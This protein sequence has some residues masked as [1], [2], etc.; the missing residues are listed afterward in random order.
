[1]DETI[2]TIW[3]RINFDQFEKPLPNE[4]ELVPLQKANPVRFEKK[5]HNGL[6]FELEFI[7][8]TALIEA[9]NSK[10]KDWSLKKSKYLKSILKELRNF[11]NELDKNSK[12]DNV[13]YAFNRIAHHQF[14]WQEKINFYSLFRYYFL[15]NNP[16]ME[17][18]IKEKIGLTPFEIFIIGMIL[19]F[20]FRDRFKLLCPI[21]SHIP[22]IS[23]DNIKKFIDTFSI[24]L[25]ELQEEIKKNFDSSEK[26][27]FSF[28]PLIAK[29][30]IKY[31][32]SIIAPLPSFIYWQITKGLYYSVVDCVGFDNAFG[33]SFEDFTG[34]LMK[35]SINKK[36]FKIIPEH[37][38]KSGKDRKDSVDWLLKDDSGLIFIECKTKR[39]TMH[40]KFSYELNDM[41]TD[42]NKMVS[43]ISQAY[44][45]YV[46]YKS[47]LYETIKYDSKI[48]HKII[49]LTL[50]E[51][52]FGIN[53]L[54]TE[55][56]KESV[57]VKLENQ[58]IDISLLEE[59]PY[60]IMSA[61][62]YEIEIQ[63]INNLGIEKYFE[64]FDSNKIQDSKDKMEF[65]NVFAEDFDREFFSKLKR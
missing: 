47:N 5:M 63:A 17:N 11:S 12:G 6:E 44:K 14:F 20:Q 55:R 62:Q 22:E 36:N 61:H 19:T 49:I 16:K 41:E 54:I 56:V 52:Y 58:K 51:W 46:D 25:P 15:Y 28:N 42:V 1:L 27:F 2:Y 53:P 26:I 50:E 40:S 3:A 65:V 29:P 21:E 59:V 35:R 8:K 18:I 10:K 43:F 23:D 32:D 39:L 57:K 37:A 38:Y 30:I 7:L 13:L 60:Y 24:A 31:S 9:G 45:T 33:K 48:S 34:T 64:E 4:I